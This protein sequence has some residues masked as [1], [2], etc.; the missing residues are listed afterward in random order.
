MVMSISC[1][2][3]LMYAIIVDGGR[4][5]RVE[6]DQILL[7]DYREAAEGSTLTLDQVLLVGGESTKIGKPTVAGAKVEAEV[8][9]DQPGTKIYVSKFRRRKNYHRRTG[10]RAIYT[11]VKITGIT[12]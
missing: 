3:A 9:G 11:K 8:L 10:H 7:I 12:A 2:G 5:Y 6:K 1:L 4:Q